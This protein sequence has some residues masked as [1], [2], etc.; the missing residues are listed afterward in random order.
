VDGVKVD[1][2]GTSSMFHAGPHVSQQYHESLEASVAQ[3]FPG[4]MM[5][6]CMVRLQCQLAAR[7][8]HAKFTT[9]VKGAS[10]HAWHHLR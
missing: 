8:C 4:N 10:L 6:N 2:Q 1:V 9:V 3:S 5:I 7:T